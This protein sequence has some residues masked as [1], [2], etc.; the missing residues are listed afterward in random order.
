MFPLGKLM[1]FTVKCQHYNAREVLSSMA[2]T[3][4]LKFSVQIDQI[5]MVV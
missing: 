3:M 2:Y 1:Q 5:E 4:N